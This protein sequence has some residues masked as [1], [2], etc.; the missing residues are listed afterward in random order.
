MPSF[1][2]PEAQLR[3]TRP[4]AARMFRAALPAKAVF[5]PAV[6]TSWSAVVAG[7]GAL[8]GPGLL[9]LQVKFRAVD[10]A[11]RADFTFG[12]AEM[13][14]LVNRPFAAIWTATYWVA[15][16]AILA[17]GGAAL[18]LTCLWVRSRK[19]SSLHHISI[20]VL[21]AALLGPGVDAAIGPKLLGALEF[22]GWSRSP[23]FCAT[24]RNPP[25]RNTIL[26]MYLIWLGAAA[27]AAMA[28]GFIVDR[29]IS[30]VPEA[31]RS[32]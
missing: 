7:V 3:P 30:N 10:W 23:V 27:F 24:L 1:S 32:A 8:V 22:G 18:G 25:D 2:S 12:H 29:G 15:E 19:L 16:C 17:L 13:Q 20:C 5:L 11:Y 31:G 4:A 6:R 9:V 14:V 28:A 26:V 21:T